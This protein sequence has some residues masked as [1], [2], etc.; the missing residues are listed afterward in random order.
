MHA[1]VLILGNC[2]QLRATASGLPTVKLRAS[3]SPLP[4]APRPVGDCQPRIFNHPRSL[5]ALPVTIRA[6]N[7]HSPCKRAKMA[8]AIALKDK[9]AHLWKGE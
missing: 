9:K 2:G 5:I 4:F 8:L 3:F 6:E 1:N 7:V